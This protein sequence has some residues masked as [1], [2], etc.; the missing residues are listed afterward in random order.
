MPKRLKSWL[1]ES[2]LEAKTLPT[3]TERT[4][5]NT[6]QHIAM[7]SPSFST[8]VLLAHTP[9]PPSEHFPNGGRSQS[10]HPPGSNI[11]SSKIHMGIL[12]PEA[13]TTHHTTPPSPNPPK[14]Y[15]T[16]IYTALHPNGSQQQTQLQT[17]CTPQQFFKRQACPCS[18]VTS[19]CTPL[20]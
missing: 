6:K 13:I 16:N 9:K 7:Q 12:S 17:H 8:S 3:R 19:M 5:T 15:R 2:I 10:S 18:V 1:N 11:E 4:T 14:L 20:T